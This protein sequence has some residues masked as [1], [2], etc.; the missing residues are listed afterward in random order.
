VTVR[1]VLSKLLNIQYTPVNGEIP[2]DVVGGVLFLFNKYIA[3]LAD[4]P[5]G[6]NKSKRATDDDFT[7]SSDRLFQA[8]TY[9]KDAAIR[10]PLLPVKRTGHARSVVVIISVTRWITDHSQ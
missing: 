4:L 5:S 6:L 2:F 10:V 9:E 7:T 1:I 3:R 8:S